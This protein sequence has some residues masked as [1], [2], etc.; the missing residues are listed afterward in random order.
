[1]ATA[2]GFAGAW[3]NTNRDLRATK[4]ELKAAKESWL[5]EVNHS[6]SLQREINRLRRELKVKEESWTV[7]NQELQ[8]ALE[9]SIIV[10]KVYADQNYNQALDW[11][12]HEVTG[13][14][15]GFEVVL[16]T[17]EKRNNGSFNHVRVDSTTATEGEYRFTV[18]PGEYFVG[19]IY[20]ENQLFS[21]RY[22]HII[23][24]NGGNMVVEK[25]QILIG[26]T[27]L[28]SDNSRG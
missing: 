22:N 21:R 13:N 12:D 9:Q 26:P 17:I 25:G 5:N 24:I 2:A 1:M 4:Q 14:I 11:E 3:H 7:A 18:D 20:N 8:R 10:G 23:Y 16:Y 15:S 6:Q 27:I 28:L 19:V